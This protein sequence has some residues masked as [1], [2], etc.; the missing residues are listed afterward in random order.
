MGKETKGKELR[1]EVAS[2]A[3][4]SARTSF[5]KLGPAF[6]THSRKRLLTLGPKLEW[7]G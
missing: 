6:W 2:P 4:I 5:R 3:G 1:K 7:D